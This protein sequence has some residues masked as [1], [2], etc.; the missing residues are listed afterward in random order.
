MF[1]KQLLREHKPTKEQDEKLVSQVK[2][3]VDQVMQMSIGKK[4]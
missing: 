3:Q 1:I 4:E 2:A